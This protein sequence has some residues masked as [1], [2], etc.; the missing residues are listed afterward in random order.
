VTPQ[1]QSR[2]RRA[3]QTAT[4]A[5]APLQ[6]VPDGRANSVSS[7]RWTRRRAHARLQRLRQTGRTQHRRGAQS[8]LAEVAETLQLDSHG[9]IA[10]ALASRETWSGL[11]VHWPVDGSNERL[12][13]EMSGLPVFDRDASSKVSAA[14]AFA[15]T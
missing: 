10:Q 3:R 9:Q 12:A 13:V 11:V 1:R 6:A 5:A 14:S 8:A 15:A 7:G 4:D 2:L